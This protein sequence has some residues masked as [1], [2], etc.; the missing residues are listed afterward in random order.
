METLISG[1]EKILVMLYAL[2]NGFDFSAPKNFAELNEN[3]R[4]E[5]K[6]VEAV[7]PSVFNCCV[8]TPGKVLVYNTL[9]NT[10]MKLTPA[11][12]LKLNGK[13]H[14]GREL[15]LKFLTEGLCVPAAIDERESYRLWRMEASKR[16][17]YLSVN[18]TTTLK[19]NARCPYCYEQGVK[20]VDFDETKIDALIDFI[21]RHKKD[22]PVKLNWFGGE[23]L[24]NPKIIDEVTRRLGESGIEFTSFVI[25]NGNLITRRLIARQFK[26]WN[27]RGVQIT[28]DGTAKQYAKRKGYVDR[29][30]AV[31]KKIL[32]RIAWLA[33]ADIHVDLRLN[34]D[35]ENMSDIMDLLY[36][37]Q[38]RFDSNKNVVYYPAFVTG[39]KDKLSDA[40][41][42]SFVKEMFRTIANPAKMSIT[43]RLY[44]FPRSLPC[45]RNDPQA[46]SVD[47]YGRVYNCEHLVGRKDKALGTLK[48]FNEKD[49]TAR[50]EEPLREECLSCVFLPKCMS[51]C[52]SNLRTGDAACMIERY[53]IQA[54]MEFMCE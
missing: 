16:R 6:A 53:M 25:T 23:P 12:F 26:R 5:M 54:Y 39:V 29:Q 40:D 47:V 21:K 30:R 50:L 13:R 45:M 10:M 2:A 51:G 32:N 41:K 11:E 31:F 8:E 27:L 20:H 19:C 3:F 4:A 18:I 37:L 52:A 33:E 48:R 42:I 49:N 24:L 1:N 35:R 36:V 34:I 7:K 9:Y 43:N 17:E 28:L 14:C 38:A 22:A 15:K 46:F 44:S